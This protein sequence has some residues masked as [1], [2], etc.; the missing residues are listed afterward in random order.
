[1][2]H[3]Y[4]N[5]KTNLRIPL[6]YTTIS[7]KEE[8]GSSAKMTQNKLTSP[9]SVFLLRH[10]YNMA[11]QRFLWT[12]PRTWL[13]STIYSFWNS[14]CLLFHGNPVIDWKAIHFSSLRHQLQAERFAE[15]F[16]SVLGNGHNELI[17]PKLKYFSDFYFQLILLLFLFDTKKTKLTHFVQTIPILGA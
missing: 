16:L 1:M 11:A 17:K 10:A 5:V 9:L 4:E 12:A 7:I 8:T 14:F 6:I 15:Y 2:W 13:G 3:K